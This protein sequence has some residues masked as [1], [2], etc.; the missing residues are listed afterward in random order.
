LNLARTSAAFAAALLP[1]SPAN[2]AP[3]PGVY[4]NVCISRDTGDHGGVELHLSYTAGKPVV[5]LKLCE[6]GCWAEPARA[7]R[8]TKDGLTFIATNQ[9]FDERGA[10]LPTEDH[11]FRV[12]FS[13]TT[14]TLSSPDR[15]GYSRLR[16]KRQNFTEPP[17]SD[18]RDPP[19][20]I[21]RC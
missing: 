20:P 4:S 3:A 10:P 12:S 8:V 21:R 17:S 1:V 15:D 7:A 6:G 5:G 14:A 16:L 13:G 11:H 19:T 9:M 2:A 18:P